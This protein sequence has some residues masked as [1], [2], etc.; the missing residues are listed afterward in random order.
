M[1]D[2]SFAPWSQNPQ[3]FTVL[4]VA[5]SKKVIKIFNYPILYGETRDLLAI[6]GVAEADIR[7]SLLKGELNHKIRA[8][9]AIVVCSDIDLL[10]F[11]LVQKSF[12]QGAGVVHGLDVA[13]AGALTATEHETLRQLIHFIDQGPGDGFAS[14]AFKT[15]TPIGAAFPTTITWWID[16]TQTKKL[17]EKI[18]TYNANQVPTTIVWHM[19]DIDG[20]TIIHTVIDSFAY[21]NNVFEISR[22]RT[23]T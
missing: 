19:Y 18:I 10:Q 4:N 7:A 17:V 11:N 9:E 13:D 1:G 22:T 16:N 6:P 14:G 15:I 5:A 8:G 3:C 23:I 2:N 12:L 21:T 20:T